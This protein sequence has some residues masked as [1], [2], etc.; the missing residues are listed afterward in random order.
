MDSQRLEYAI[1]V[2]LLLLRIPD[3]DYIE[4]AQAIIEERFI[5]L[6]TVIDDY[7]EDLTPKENR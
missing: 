3:N 2:I 7:F 1:H 6:G 4:N 5:N